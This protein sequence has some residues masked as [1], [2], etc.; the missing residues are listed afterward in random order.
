M[1]L[2]TEVEINPIQGDLDGRCAVKNFLGKDLGQ[3][4]QMFREASLVYQED[5]MFMGPAAFRFYVQAA[6]SYIK[7]KAAAG[8]S[9]LINCFAGILE[10]RLEFEADELVSVAEMLASVCGFIV[11]DYDSFDLIP[12]VYGDLRPRYESLQKRFLEMARSDGSV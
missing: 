7:S 9:D 6:I 1:R 5:L 12:E 2:P 11:H 4:E 3:A 10:F 8:D